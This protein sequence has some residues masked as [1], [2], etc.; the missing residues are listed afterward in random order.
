MLTLKLQAKDFTSPSPQ[1]IPKQ[2]QDQSIFKAEQFRPKSCFWHSVSVVV[3]GGWGGMQSHFRVWPNYGCIRLSWGFDKIKN[4]LFFSLYTFP[5]LPVHLPPVWQNIPQLMYKTS[6]NLCRRLRRNIFYS[7]MWFTLS[8]L[9]NPFSFFWTNNKINCTGFK[10]HWFVCCSCCCI[11]A[12]LIVD[13][14]CF[15]YIR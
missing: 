10:T 5:H 8:L 15:R 4:K 6:T 9:I 7:N 14:D 1:M 13:W 2:S 3:G 11:K 12:V